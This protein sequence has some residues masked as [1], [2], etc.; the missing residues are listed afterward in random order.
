[1]TKT[2]TAIQAVLAAL[3]SA[4]FAD[5]GQTKQE[6]VRVP[7]QASPVFGAAGGELRTFGGRA[8]FVLPG[9]ELDGPMNGNTQVRVTVGARTTFFYRN[10]YRGWSQYTTEIA[11]LRT[12]DL[13]AIQEVLASLNNSKP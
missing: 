5:D 2:D 6:T 13:V 9:S 4:G 10:V 3:A 7:T 11:R 12:K 8:R 1:M